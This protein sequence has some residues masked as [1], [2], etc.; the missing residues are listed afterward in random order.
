ML[1]VVAVFM[2]VM[3]GTGC[4]QKA[5]VAPPPPPPEVVVVTPTQRDVSIKGEWL[6]T[7]DGLVNAEV[8]SRVQGYVQSQLYTEG[9]VVKVGA[10]MYKIDP[11]PFLA[12][13]EQAKADLSKAKADLGRTELDVARLEPLAPSGA[14]SQQEVDNARQLNEANKAQVQAA[15][16]RVDLAMLNLQYT[17]VVSPIE[18]VAGISKAQIGDLVGGPGGPVLTTISTLDPIRV[19]FP[20]SEQE[21]IRVAE[22]VNRMEQQQATTQRV[23]AELELILADGSVFPHKGAID[24]VNREVVTTT[25]T[26]QIGATFPNPGNVLRPGQYA[27]VR[28]VS[29]VRKDALLIP[30]RCVFEVQG[31]SQVAVVGADNKVSIRAVVTAERIGSE[32]II[33]EGIKAGEQVVYEGVQKVRDGMTVS[34][35]FGEPAASG[36]GVPTTA[37]S[38]TGK[39]N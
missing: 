6:G 15:Q 39:A 19:Y 31:R 33:L 26:I 5:E 32:W 11:R 14:V 28:A 37:K 38:N 35:R 13:L 34:V 29:K 25:G 2:G 1:G 23:K 9:S 7:T 4:E 18:G 21:Y 27:R 8:R 16:A 36:Q 22:A 20:I 24:F 3:G 30:Q 10:P 17:D 12:S